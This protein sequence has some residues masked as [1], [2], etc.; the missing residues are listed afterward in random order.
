[1]IRKLAMFDLL[2]E[3]ALYRSSEYSKYVGPLVDARA[4]LR[5]Q[6]IKVET[7]LIKL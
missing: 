3:M 2:T 1:M 4:T 6:K 5:N 7:S